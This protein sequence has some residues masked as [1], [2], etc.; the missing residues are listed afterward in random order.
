MN[1]FAEILREWREL[2]RDAYR[3][4]IDDSEIVQDF[5]DRL[6]A[7]GHRG[8]FR[9]CRALAHGG[10]GDDFALAET[11]LAELAPFDE[12]R[13]TMA[14]LH[15]ECA[16]LRALAQ[17]N[18]YALDQLAHRFRKPIGL[19]RDI[20]FELA[21]LPHVA[22]L[23]EVPDYCVEDA[24]VGPLILIQKRKGEKRGMLAELTLQLIGAGSGQFYP[25]PAMTL[26]EH[27]EE[28]DHALENART[29]LIN[30]G[31]WEN[32][33]DIRWHLRAKSRKGA[34]NSLAG[35]SAGGAFGLMGA[36]LLLRSAS[37][38]PEPHTLSLSA[39]G[40]K[41]LIE[42]L[43]SISPSDLAEAAVSAAITG[44]GEL[45]RVEGIVEK[46]MAVVKE[47][48][49]IK[50]REAEVLEPGEVASK[51]T[52]IPVGSVLTASSQG[53]IEGIQF[54]NG[55]PRDWGAMNP[56]L[57]SDIAIPLTIC[58]GPTLADALLLRTVDRQTPAVKI[59]PCA[60]ELKRHVD[61]VPRV[62]LNSRLA[63]FRKQRGE[64][65][66]FF[67]VTGDYGT[68]K[69]G[70]I[71]YCLRNGG[72]KNPIYH[73]IRKHRQPEEWDTPTVFFRSLT[74]QLRR[75]HVLL[76]RPNELAMDDPEEEFFAVLKR[77]SEMGIKETIWI[78]ALDEVYG[79]QGKLRGTAALS[80]LS[81]ERRKQLPWGR[82]ATEEKE[83]DLPPGITFVLTSRTGDHLSWLLQ[84]PQCEEVPLA[85]MVEGSK[86]DVRA[87][88]EDQSQRLLSLSAPFIDKAVQCS[89]GNF[90]YAVL[91]VKDLRVLRPSDYVPNRIPTD[92]PA[93]MKNLLDSAVTRWATQSGLPE[94]AA[95]N[96]VDDVLG[97][98]AS[99]AELLRFAD[100]V[101]L[102][103]LDDLEAV[104]MSKLLNACGEF[105]R[106]QANKE[107]LGFFHPH[108]REVILQPLDSA[109]QQE[110]HQRLAARC[111]QWRS[112]EG[113]AAAY[114]MRHRLY[115][116]RLAE[117]WD[118]LAVNLTDFEFLL[119]KIGAIPHPGCD[120]PPPHTVFDL[121]RTFRNVLFGAPSLPPSHPAKDRIEA[122]YRAI[123]KHCDAINKDPGLLVQ[124]VYNGLWGQKDDLARSADSLAAARLLNRPWLKAL[125]QPSGVESTLLVRNYFGHPRQVNAVAFV[126][127]EKH[128]LLA[129]GD[130]DHG[131]ILWDIQTGRLRR[132]LEGH[133]DFVTSLV[134]TEPD[135]IRPD[136]LLVS[137]SLDDYIRFWDPQSGHPLASVVCL[138]DAPLCL[139]LCRESRRIAV[140]CWSGR[141]RFIDI[142][143]M[144][145][146]DSPSS[147]G[148]QGIVEAGDDVSRP[149][150]TAIHSV[151]FNQDGTLLASG[152]RDKR[153]RIHNLAKANT[154]GAKKTGGVSEA[155]DSS[156]PPA[157]LGE[158]SDL[159]LPEQAS[160]VEAL[161]FSPDSKTKTIA[162]G[163][164]L[165]NGVVTL[166]DAETGAF[167]R[168]I[169]GLHN[170]GIWA[171]VFSPEGDLLITGSW[172]RTIAVTDART[173]E[174]L[175]R[176]AL[177]EVVLALAVT[178][179]G[180]LLASG[181]ADR[182]VG[183]WDLEKIREMGKSQRFNRNQCA[184]RNTIHAAQ[185][186]SDGSIL[187]S[188]SADGDLIVWDG[189]TGEHRKT[190]PGNTSS[191]LA[192][193][194]SRDAGMAV[195]GGSGGIRLWDLAAG[196]SIGAL[197]GHTGDIHSLAFSIKDPHLLASGGHNCCVML[198]NVNERA[199]LKTFSGH[200]SIVR[201]LAFS[202]RDTLLASVGDDR[203]VI[204]WD[205]ATGAQ[206]HVL[207]GPNGHR[208]RVKSVAFS[209]DGSLLAS[210]GGETVK[211]W[212]VQ[213]GKHKITLTGPLAYGDEIW[214]LLFSRDGKYL[215][216]GGKDK[217][218]CV[219]EVE[220]GRM[221]AWM[222]CANNVLA[223]WI[224]PAS[225][226]LRV[227]DSGNAEGKPNCY[228]LELCDRDRG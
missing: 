16:R 87:Y 128:R 190:L 131:I 92:L 64:A 22:P 107:P 97:L 158:R 165:G 78:D 209:F 71:A 121:L 135:P 191:I 66:G 138:K 111:L 103:G 74:A 226:E 106:G 96:E 48:K 41:N 14:R 219:Y 207:A 18:A 206:V 126:K 177:G 144:T 85:A 72:T 167:Q 215:V 104:R 149:N 125:R 57:F 50:K 113:E 102:L 184:H 201:S 218:L 117:Q 142:D 170:D 36:V 166:W 65:G 89:D 198:W 151:A 112:L 82:S 32:H 30:L 10:H 194:L 132:V 212:D 80:V 222:P 174:Q 114:A 150:T 228:V 134:F 110:F 9:A 176:I 139:A 90:L 8:W 148:G 180:K 188:G 29:F 204:V 227:A 220:T 221:L 129:S 20:D 105:V 76:R 13:A 118:E 108:F 79:A 44:T 73:F 35:G 120:G 42:V 124:Q 60:T 95:R 155:S 39:P 116:L 225:S 59:L 172:D 153:V 52:L 21:S 91:L 101:A 183:L 182:L 211:V 3:A 200:T 25:S 5:L 26:V 7:P 205:Y 173:G 58:R 56:D 185:F 94:P 75:K 203:T 100:L 208:R 213:T 217:N 47:R 70:F 175:W 179:D 68:G 181:S 143:R 178:D 133:S 24:I 37:L 81:V 147:L 51:K 38:D 156:S 197:S 119:T 53:E 2:P 83:P 55:D 159:T 84:S 109:R 160:W 216:A 115:H 15:L 34:L 69:S 45:K 169:S 4:L 1:T 192:L 224:N 164:G 141:V 46:I 33:L 61:L 146:A 202:P 130:G 210:G 63:A 195:T 11:I 67:L 123:G 54:P 137:A 223:A 77:L 12:A 168:K 163:L 140:G 49:A 193:A 40:P 152:G 199:Y 17:S 19:V 28:F 214:T 122:I 162:C 6:T 171:L 154:K 99:T 62:E 186:A 196:K 23:G 161:A 145:W 157:F 31:L 88:F 136:G 93:A 187:V 98:L 43:R 86:A 127:S 189:L 27:N